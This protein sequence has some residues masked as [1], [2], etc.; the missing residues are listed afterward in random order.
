MDRLAKTGKKF[1][2][3]RPTFLSWTGPNEKDPFD[4]FH[5][6]PISSTVTRFSVLSMG[7]NTYQC[8][9]YGLLTADLLVFSISTSMYNNSYVAVTQC[10][11]WLRETVYSREN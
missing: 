8:I 4:L 6:N 9:F 1:R 5:C 3:S 11:F 7:E 10:T 2:K